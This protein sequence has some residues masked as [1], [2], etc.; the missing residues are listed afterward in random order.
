MILS[1]AGRSVRLEQT[2]SVGGKGL[3]RRFRLPGEKPGVE[4]C[5]SSEREKGWLGSGKAGR[6]WSLG[7]FGVGALLLCPLA[8]LI[9]FFSDPVV[10][11]Q[12][13]GA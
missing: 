12:Q 4:K 11:E 5:N 10:I 13:L 1:A 6:F 9:Q 8:D 3:G 2:T 7:L